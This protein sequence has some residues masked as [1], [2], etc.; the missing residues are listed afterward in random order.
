LGLCF[1]RSKSII[2]STLIGAAAFGI[3]LKLLISFS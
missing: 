2:L 3:T 1:Y